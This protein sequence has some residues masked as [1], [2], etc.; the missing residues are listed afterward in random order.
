MNGT[1]GQQKA[2]SQLLHHRRMETPMISMETGKEREKE[3][4]GGGGGGRCR[5]RCVYVGWMINE[6]TPCCHL[7]FGI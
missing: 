6:S 3:R 5:G 1:A 4:L 2:C 7:Y